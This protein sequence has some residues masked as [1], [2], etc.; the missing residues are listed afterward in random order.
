MS[1]NI[2]TWS[3][4]FQHQQK[5]K[6]RPWRRGGLLNLTKKFPS[7]SSTHKYGKRGFTHR[8]LTEESLGFFAL[9]LN[10]IA[11]VGPRENKL[12][13]TLHSQPAPAHENGQSEQTCKT[14]RLC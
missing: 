11:H 7:L 2:L 10:P 3:A 1:H 12:V 13:I 4:G 8:K 6:N 5:A 14:P 9:A